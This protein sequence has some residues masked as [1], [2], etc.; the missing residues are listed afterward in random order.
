MFNATRPAA[1]FACLFITAL[2]VTPAQASAATPSGMP[3]TD[4]YNDGLKNGWQDWG[5]AHKELKP[6]QPARLHMTKYSGWI[7]AHRDLTGNYTALMIRLRAPAKFGQFLEVRLGHN[8]AGADAFPKLPLLPGDGV[9]GSDGFVQYTF[10]MQSLNP[11]NDP[12]DRIVLHATRAVDDTAVEVAHIA[13]VPAAPGEFIARAPAPPNTVKASHLIIDCRAPKKT[14]SPL[15]YGIAF[16]PRK[17]GKDEHLWKL[18]ST[19]RR[20]GGNPASR[21]NWRLGNAWNTASDWFF[22]NVNYT[23][24][25][26]YSW[27]DFLSENAKHDVQ[28]AMTVPML[29]WV[30]KDTSS[31]SFSVAAMGAQQFSQKD[32]GNGMRKGGGKIPSPPR[33]TTSIEASPAFV[34][35]WVS[36]MEAWQAQEHKGSI[37]QYILDNEPALWNST[38]RDVHPDAL[39][40][41]ELLSKT[42]AY[43]SAVRR[44][45]PHAQIAGPAEWGWPAYFF[46]AKDQEVGFRLKP[47]RR[48]HGDVPLLAW[49][50]QNLKKH[51]TKTGEH[52]LDVVDLHYYPQTSGVYGHGEDVSAKGAATR[53]RATRSLWDP[54]FKDESWIADNIALLPRMQSLIDANYPGRRISIGEYNFGGEKHISGALALA[55][56]LGRFGQANVLSAYLWTYPPENSPAAHAFRAYRDYDGAGGQFP[57]AGLATQGDTNLSLFAA[58]DPKS[59]KIVAVALNLAATVDA[60][61]T[62]TLQGCGEYAHARTFALDASSPQLHAIEAATGSTHN[63]LHQKLPAYSLTV[64]ELSR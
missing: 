64:I 49:Y 31:Y 27:K 16:S 45:A 3:P 40:Y 61:T 13:L 35:E 51:A 4:V 60:E 26:N 5:W 24:V 2:G 12:F 50:L 15:I 62:I 9:R 63:A 28:A 41:D 30:A 22:S 33:R 48:A 43:G 32:A 18:N 47:D 25:E 29:G 17:V 11:S 37:A 34:G 6:G 53:L 23:N 44:A 10:P 36:A 59:D 54:T 55:E 38:H 14:I 42:V 8:D 56:A 46:S 21:Y 52:V 39:T 58:Q 19:V 1:L 57:T 20:W 7:L